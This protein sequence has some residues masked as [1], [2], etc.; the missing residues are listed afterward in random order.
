VRRIITVRYN[1]PAAAPGQNIDKIQFI[2]KTDARIN[3]ILMLRPR[4]GNRFTNYAI[5]SSQ[6]SGK[7]VPIRDAKRS[8]MD[9][10]AHKIR[11]FFPDIIYQIHLM[12]FT[13]LRCQPAGDP[14]RAAGS[15]R[16]YKNQYVFSGFLV[17]FHRVLL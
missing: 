8:L 12:F 11:L 4:K 2:H 17:N 1:L 5:P 15:E 10:G 9:A 13:Q 6:Y 7:P 14:F 16:W 3:L